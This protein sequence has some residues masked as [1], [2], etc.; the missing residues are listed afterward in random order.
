MAVASS[1]SGLFRVTLL[2]RILCWLVRHAGKQDIVI[3]PPGGLVVAWQAKVT[4]QPI[5]FPSLFQAPM[6]PT[7]GSM[8]PAGSIM[9]GYRSGMGVS[10][11]S[12]R[13]PRAILRKLF[14]TSRYRA[15]S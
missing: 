8:G 11:G 14:R 13:L 12:S 6:A 10:M 3:V 2:F 15:G 1:A 5:S 7:S 4:T 9:S